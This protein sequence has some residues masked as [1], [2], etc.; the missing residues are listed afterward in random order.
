MPD[1]G[2]VYA[3]HSVSS[4]SRP[5]ADRFFESADKTKELERSIYAAKQL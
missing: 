3:E 1:D 2:R 4:Q 5:E